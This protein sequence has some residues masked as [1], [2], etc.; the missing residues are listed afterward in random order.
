MLFSGASLHQP[1][2]WGTSKFCNCSLFTK[3]Y[4]LFVHFVCLFRR[5]FFVSSVYSN[6]LHTKKEDAQY[7]VSCTSEFVMEHHMRR[8]QH[9][10]QLKTSQQNETNCIHRIALSLYARRLCLP[11]LRTS[12]HS[13][14]SICTLQV[15]KLFAKNLFQSQITSSIPSYPRRSPTIFQ[16]TECVLLLF[17]KHFGQYLV[18]TYSV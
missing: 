13:R 14:A 3:N 5:F 8:C 10:M 11:V 1:D 9:E 6:G 15:V 16:H 17:E 12:S 7:G 18:E 4:N 2:F